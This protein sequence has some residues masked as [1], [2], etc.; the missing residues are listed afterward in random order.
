MKSAEIQE[1]IVVNIA[2][3]MV[4]TYIPCDDTV[5]IGDHWDGKAFT[6]PLIEEKIH[7]S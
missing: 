3:G 7:G 2:L 6:K 5:S 4:A 1:G